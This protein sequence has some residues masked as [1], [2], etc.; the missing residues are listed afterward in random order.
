MQ[1]SEVSRLLPDALCYLEVGDVA[2]HGGLPCLCCRSI[3]RSLVHICCTASPPP[4]APCPAFAAAV[5]PAG[6]VP[7]AVHM[8]IAVC[9]CPRACSHVKCSS[10]VPLDQAP[11]VSLVSLIPNA[12][13]ILTLRSW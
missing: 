10:M 6:S 13:C 11:H 2:G 9:I 1:P 5:L 7:A 12:C 3:E 4:G 8:L